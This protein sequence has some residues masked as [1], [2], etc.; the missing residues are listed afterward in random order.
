[1]IGGR[2]IQIAYPKMRFLRSF[3]FGSQPKTRIELLIFVKNFEI[4]SDLLSDDD[5]KLQGNRIS[6]QAINHS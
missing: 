6:F 2:Q 1:M 5:L 3:K 4:V